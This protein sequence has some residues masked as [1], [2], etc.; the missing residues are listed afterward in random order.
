MGQIVKATHEHAKIV[1]LRILNESE[2]EQITGEVSL[3]L[4]F[5]NGGLRRIHILKET[6]E[7]VPASA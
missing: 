4:V 1:L 7:Q 2:R 3:R 6:T 5:N